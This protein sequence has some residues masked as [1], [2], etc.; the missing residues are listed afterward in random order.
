MPADCVTAIAK[1][2]LFNGPKRKDAICRGTSLRDDDVDKA[3]EHTW[4]ERDGTVWRLSAVGQ[5][6]L[7]DSA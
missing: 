5:N 1:F 3:L 6:N 7:K 4:F 2:L